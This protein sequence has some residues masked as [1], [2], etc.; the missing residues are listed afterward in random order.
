[1]ANA[2]ELRCHVE[3]MIWRGQSEPAPTSAPTWMDGA[4]IG[5]FSFLSL[6]H[7]RSTFFLCPFS[8]LIS[9]FFCN[10]IFSPPPP[11][12]FL[13]FFGFWNF[14]CPPTHYPPLS[15]SNL[16]A[17][18]FKL[19]VDS[20]PIF[21]LTCKLKMCYSHPHPPTHPTIDLPTNTLSR[22]LLPNPTYMAAP[23]YMV[24]IAID[25]QWL[26]TMRKE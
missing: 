23:T 8:A 21:L 12:Q 13:F 14:S 5:W 1:M 4:L 10:F 19:K 17:Y 22:Y 2:G 3:E 9:V 26:T 7:P 15:P 11:T 20:S 16:L 24:A 6:C 25:P 18:I